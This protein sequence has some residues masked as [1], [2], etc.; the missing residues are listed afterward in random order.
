MSAASTFSWVTAWSRNIWRVMWRS[1][2]LLI[3]ESM[4]RRAASR[5]IWSWM[6]ASASF[7]SVISRLV[8]TMPLTAGWSIM[9]LPTDS[10]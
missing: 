1:R 3:A 8:S 7:R 2:L 4:S 6:R 9:L 10:T 5:L